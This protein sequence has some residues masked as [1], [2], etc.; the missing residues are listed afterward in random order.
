MKVTG[1][2]LAGVGS[3]TTY[4]RQA[5]LQRKPHPEFRR[6]ALW[7]KHAKSVHWQ[8]PPN[9]GIGHQRKSHPQTFSRFAFCLLLISHF[10]GVF[11]RVRRG[12][13]EAL[14]ESQ[15]LK[16]ENAAPWG[17]GARRAAQGR[18]G[19]WGPCAA[20]KARASQARSPRVLQRTGHLGRIQ[21]GLP[22][23]FPPLSHI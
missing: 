7:S 17:S 2:I 23:E 9:C 1:E 3:P 4:R 6:F 13:K 22:A 20:S 10:C 8:A 19:S 16:G 5:L 12:E 11:S 18:N 15:R 14:R 21:P